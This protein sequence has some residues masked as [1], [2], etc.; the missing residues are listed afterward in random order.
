MGRAAGFVGDRSAG[1]TA[2]RRARRRRPPESERAGF[3]RVLIGYFSDAPDGFLLGAHAAATTRAS[4]GGPAGGT[5]SDETRGATHP[6]I[7]TGVDA[8]DLSISGG[9]EPDR[10]REL[11][12]G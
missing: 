9:P 1:G 7:S 8:A 12:L 4:K 10:E 6:I 2:L 3:D 11:H 5:I